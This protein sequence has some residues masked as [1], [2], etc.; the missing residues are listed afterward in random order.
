M[1]YKAMIKTILNPDLE[2]AIMQSYPCGM[3]W[4]FAGLQLYQNTRC[5]WI[6]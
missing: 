1:P 2:V 4:A 6:E 3:T 5:E